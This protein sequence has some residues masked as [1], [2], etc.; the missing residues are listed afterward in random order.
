M[1]QIVCVLWFRETIVTDLQVFSC[2][3]GRFLVVTT[4]ATF[5]SFRHDPVPLQV[6]KNIDSQMLN[7][8]CMLCELVSLCNEQNPL[9]LRRLSGHTRKWTMSLF[10]WASK[11][12][13]AL[14][15]KLGCVTVKKTSHYAS[16]GVRF[17]VLLVVVLLASHSACDAPRPSWR[18][19]SFLAV[20]VECS[21]FLTF[22]IHE[23][24][25]SKYLI[26]ATEMKRGN[27]R[28]MRGVM[29]RVVRDDGRGT[30]LDSYDS[31]Q[32]SDALQRRASSHDWYKAR[33]KHALHHEE[34]W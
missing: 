22:K 30:R 18:E 17:P 9:I 1:V 20:Q 25:L 5:E 33:I 27:R 19:F 13:A 12:P 28:R 6:W 14:F 24:L 29:R 16:L 7:C 8:L 15:C 4:I 32:H 10:V 34:T 26:K 2:S 11:S 3:T 31:N 23:Y 21:V